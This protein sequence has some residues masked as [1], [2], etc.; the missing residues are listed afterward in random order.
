MVDTIEY[1]GLGV[2]GHYLGGKNR[3]AFV[4]LFLKKNTE[5]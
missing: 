4:P 3:Y 2:G 1:R 5:K